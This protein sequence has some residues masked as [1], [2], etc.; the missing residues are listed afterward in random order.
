MKYAPASVPATR[1]TWLTTRDL[2]NVGIFAALYIVVLFVSGMIGFVAPAFMFVGWTIGILLN[3]I[4]VALFLARTP[5][6]GALTTLGVAAGLFMSISGHPMFTLPI[7]VLLGL[8]ADLVFNQ[9]RT[10][11]SI[12]FPAAYAIFSLWMVAPLIP[13]LLNAKEYFALIAKQMG[14]EYAAG[15]AQIFQ[16]WVLGVWAIVIFVLGIIGGVIGVRV[17]KKHFSRAGLV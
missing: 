6:M 3:G 7:T 1:M 4:V 10:R 11:P 8:I 12:G 9:L 17:A 16:P 14:Q 15:M 5:R 2:I 13:I